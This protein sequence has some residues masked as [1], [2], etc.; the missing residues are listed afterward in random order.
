ML[1]KKIK[2]KKT[3]KVSTSEKELIPFDE[4]RSLLYRASEICEDHAHL[5]ENIDL[6]GM[7]NQLDKYINEL[8]VK[9]YDEDD[10]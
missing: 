8:N 5:T 1:T 2:M 3:K 6:I 7:C 9:V 4:L 10:K